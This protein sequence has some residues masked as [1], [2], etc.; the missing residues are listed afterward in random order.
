MNISGKLHKT[1]LNLSL[2][3]FNYLINKEPKK[4]ILLFSDPRGGSTW[5]TE[6]IRTIPN[7]AA[8]YEPLHIQ[9]SKALQDLNFGWRQFIPEDEDWPEALHYFTNLFRGKSLNWH[10]FSSTDY[11]TMWEADILIFKFC[12]ANRLIPWITK[13]FN[14]EKKPIYMLRHPFSIAASRMKH[15]GWDHQFNWIKI[16]GERYKESYQEHESFLK[17]LTRPEEAYV[18]EWCISNSIPLTNPCKNTDWITIYYEDLVLQPIKVLKM[19][20]S[21]WDM[22]LIQKNTYDKLNNASPTTLDG[23]PLT[24]NEQL[25]QWKRFFSEKQT[26]K[27]HSILEYFKMD[28]YYSNEILPLQMS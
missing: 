23:S 15:S 26:A 1:A 18:A 27:M 5:L 25:E 28:I 16:F 14:F 11:K 21:S 9:H 4:N 22:N 10:S 2:N 6:I 19:L 17:S 20:E 3:V 12:R 7:S 24:G 8:I 13:N